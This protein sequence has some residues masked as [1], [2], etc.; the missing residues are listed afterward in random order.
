MY[1]F[2]Y[3]LC[4]DL[5]YFSLTGEY[6]NVQID[7]GS[8]VHNIIVI[9]NNVLFLNALWSLYTV[10]LDCFLSFLFQFAQFALL[11]QVS[12]C[13]AAVN[14]NFTCTS[15]SKLPVENM[16]ML[17]LFETWVA[18]YSHKHLCI[19]VALTW[20]I[21][22]WRSVLKKMLTAFFGLLCMTKKKEQNLIC[23]KLHYALLSYPVNPFFFLIVNTHTFFR[24]IY[25]CKY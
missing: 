25:Y 20:H 8:S 14:I 11:T 5:I 4:I 21:L 6:K 10:S 3:N 24:I 1:I 9:K 13:T 19:T 7:R 2:V 18:T 17:S 16:L 23:F 22:I 15:M 12:T